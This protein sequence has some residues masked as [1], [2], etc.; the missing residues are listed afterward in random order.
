MFKGDEVQSTTTAV[1]YDDES[2]DRL[3]QCI[4]TYDLEDSPLFFP[5]RRPT[6]QPPSSAPLQRPFPARR[7]WHAYTRHIE[8]PERAQG[9]GRVLRKEG[10]LLS[11]LTMGDMS[12]E[13]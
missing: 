1:P 11:C 10:V 2:H 8:T 5:G 7:N 9:R 6:P 4:P 3:P 12:G 13:S